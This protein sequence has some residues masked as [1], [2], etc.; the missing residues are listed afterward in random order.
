[1]DLA[2]NSELTIGD[3]NLTC[4][5]GLV[6]PLLSL[7]NLQCM[8]CM[9][10]CEPHVLCCLEG[11]IMCDECYANWVKQSSTST[12]LCPSCKNDFNKPFRNL[13]I[14][15]LIAS[16]PCVCIHSGCGRTDVPRSELKHHIENCYHKPVVC[17]HSDYEKRH[18]LQEAGSCSWSGFLGQLENHLNRECPYNLASKHLEKINKHMEDLEKRIHKLRSN[19]RRLRKN[20]PGPTEKK[21][22]RI[23]RIRTSDELKKLDEGLFVCLDRLSNPN[24]C[25]ICIHYRG[26]SNELQLSHWIRLVRFPSTPLKNV[27]SDDQY[28]MN[29]TKR[30]NTTL[31]SN[32]AP[33]CFETNVAWDDQS[34]YELSIAKLTE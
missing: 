18:N 31:A 2:L 11:H 10:L 28:A 26:N 9:E 24:A 7:S 12:V 4:E 34:T 22:K 33:V 13:L 1:M 23:T 14:E 21:S 30:F 5:N 15:Q 20:M 29:F 6:R 16:L 27:D 25:G 17:P 32:K 19:E 3:T 8:V